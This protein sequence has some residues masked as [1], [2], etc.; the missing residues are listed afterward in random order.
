MW[1]GGKESETW[2]EG[3]NKQQCES[4]SSTIK[5]GAFIKVSPEDPSSHEAT[6]GR[7]ADFISTDNE[8][9]TSSF[10]F[11]GAKLFPDLSAT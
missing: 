3:C 11:N 2:G 5:G 7:A 1:G 8:L 6:E 4:I 9:C 10:S